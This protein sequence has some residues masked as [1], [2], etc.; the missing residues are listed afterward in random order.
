[1][2]DRAAKEAP[3]APKSRIRTPIAFI[4]A[5]AMTV[6]LAGTANA[7]PIGKAPTVITGA[8]SYNA[9]WYWS[10]ATTRISAGD[11]I[12]WVAG[13]GAHVIVAY[14]HRWHYFHRLPRGSSVTHPFPT[15]G[16]Y[17]FRCQIHSHIVDG[18]C[19]GMC[20]KIVVR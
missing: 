13:I 5:A 16:T 12:K 20:G 2:A 6:A 4:V 3:V 8:W 10:P 1:L 7:S 15:A 19:W 17:R 9:D 14:G 18:D 11:H